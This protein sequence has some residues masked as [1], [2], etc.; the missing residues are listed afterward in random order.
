MRLKVLILAVLYTFLLSYANPLR[1]EIESLTKDQSV[2]VGIYV[3]SLATKS[4][5]FAL[6]DKQ[7]FIP[8][9]NQKILTTASAIINL[10]PDYR[11]KTQILTDGFVKDGVLKGNLYLKGGADPSLSYE[12]LKSFADYLKQIGILKIEGDII[13]DNSF[14]LEE[15]RGHGWPEKDFEYCF[16]APFSALSLNENCLRLE[17][18]S[19][20]KRVSV[21]MYPDNEYYEIVNNLAISKKYSD[22]KVKVEGRK[23]YLTGYIKSL[24]KAEVSIPVENPS[25][26]TTSAFYKMMKESGIK[27]TG[28]YHLGK[29]PPNANPVITHKSQPLKEIIKKANKDSNNFYAEQIFRTLGKEILGKGDTET[30]ATVVINTLKKV[31]I[32]VSNIRIYDGSGLSK[33]NQLTPESIA[34]ILSYMYNTPY[35]FD[36]YQSLAV[37]GTDGTLKHRFKDVKGKI[38]AKTGY[39]K[40]VKNLSGY[41]LSDNGEVY[42]FS[43][44]VNN[45]KSTEIAN[46][47]Q[48][49]V[50]LILANGKTQL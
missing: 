30:S 5:K 44:L 10:T 22:Y 13:G 48:E 17:L 35:F 26:H 39:I 14:F 31:G 37:A 19:D 7:P 9:S 23:I 47:I 40:G 46:K 33:F 50:C 38:Y 11:F 8:A 24:S 41:I 42:V 21:K 29:T 15:G 12:D 32:D 27:I 36:F 25:L 43:I 1:E 2:D 6:K 28:K 34:K 49:S 20:K 16:T 45:L 4:F 3:E 18:I